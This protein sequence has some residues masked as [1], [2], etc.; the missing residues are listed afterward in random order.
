MDLESVNSLRETIFCWH[1]RNNLF[2]QEQKPPRCFFSTIQ[3]SIETWLL[4]NN[5]IFCD[6][7]DAF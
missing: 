3:D 7:Y 2:T 5:F 1:E 4:Q 6:L